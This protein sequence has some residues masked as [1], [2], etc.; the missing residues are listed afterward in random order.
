MKSLHD[1]Q[2]KQFEK[3]KQRE[4]DVVVRHELGIVIIE[5][6]GDK[7]I[8]ENV[9]QRSIKALKKRAKDRTLRNT[10]RA[11]KWKRGRMISNNDRL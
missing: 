3:F 9:T 6:V 5:M 1:K 8:R 7:G 10:C 2:V 4:T 11:C